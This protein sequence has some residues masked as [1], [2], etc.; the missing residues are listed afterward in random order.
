MEPSI[1]LC[2]PPPGADKAFGVEGSVVDKLF[3]LISRKRN[4]YLKGLDAAN[5]LRRLSKLLPDRACI[6]ILLVTRRRRDNKPVV[7]LSANS[8]LALDDLIENLKRWN[9]PTF[10]FF[11]VEEQVTENE[12][13]N[14]L[15]SVPGAHF[16]AWVSPKH[17]REL[18]AV[19]CEMSR[20]YGLKSL[21]R[22]EVTWKYV[23]ARLAALIAQINKHL[24]KEDGI[25]VRDVMSRDCVAWVNGDTVVKQVDFEKL[26]AGA[27]RE[28]YDDTL[29]RLADA[30][31]APR[32]QHQLEAEHLVSSQALFW[33]SELPS[34]SID[35]D[36]FASSRLAFELY[37]SKVAGWPSE[38]R[39]SRTE[40]VQPDEA[41][42]FVESFV[43]SP[44]GIYLIGSSRGGESS[45]PPAD[46]LRATLPPFK[47]LKRPVI[48]RDW[49]LFSK[50]LSNDI[51]NS[52]MPVTQCN[53]LQA[54]MFASH[55][56]SHLRDLGLLANE[57]TVSLPSEFQWEAAARGMDAFDYP[58]G[59]TFDQRRCNCNLAY[60]SA[61]T[62]PGQFS[63]GGDSPIGCQD[64]A[65]NVREWTR[66]Y[67][68]VAGIDWRRNGEPEELRDLCTV[69]PSD[70]LIIRGGSYS[71]D[72]S[73]VRCWVRNT[74]LAERSDAQ[75][76]FRLVI[77]SVTR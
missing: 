77:E 31:F 34:A 39:I 4:P 72:P 20:W 64:M 50:T 37:G 6:L 15:S 43:A 23:A 67:G 55:V 62:K 76:G 10:M 44:A 69:Q 65:G 53:A 14:E 52:D 12:F 18:V 48:W 73:C 26:T 74:Q 21:M 66:S 8:R 75:T 70:R 54:F 41:R 33:F 36:W 51:V 2:F 1:T 30:A 40:I 58:W 35:F 29:K 56:E 57:D 3:A 28:Q 7:Y 13:L 61:P 47:I 71:Y 68:G 11:V 49:N 59:N 32:N 45:E 60:G 25:R 46:P 24:D 22:Q 5:F 17:Y 27:R 9:F 19:G 42:A 63:P 16:L 38:I